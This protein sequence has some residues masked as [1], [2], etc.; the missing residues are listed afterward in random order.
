MSRHFESKNNVCLLRAA[1]FRSVPTTRIKG[2]EASN[3]ARAEAKQARAEA[4][5]ALR[6]AEAE[7]RARAQREEAYVAQRQQDRMR[8]RQRHMH[9]VATAHDL[10]RDLLLQLE[11]G[12]SAASR[13]ELGTGGQGILPARGRGNAGAQRS[14]AESGL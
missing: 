4:R 14:P 1:K 9:M 13:Q 12:D 2:P 11:A 10:A 3:S 6:Q 7:R 8:L 5:E